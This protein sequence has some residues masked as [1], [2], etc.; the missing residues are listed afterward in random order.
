MPLSFI[1]AKAPDNL[2]DA[3]VPPFPSDANFTN[4]FFPINNFP[5]KLTK[6]NSPCINKV[7]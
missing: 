2:K 7:T 4:L 1:S 5:S 3:N 6:G